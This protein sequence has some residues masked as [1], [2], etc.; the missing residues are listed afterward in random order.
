MK[1]ESSGSAKQWQGEAYT[2]ALPDDWKWWR[3]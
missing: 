1:A 3:E 2:R